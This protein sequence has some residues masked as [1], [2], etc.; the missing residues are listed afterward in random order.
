[1]DQ[2]LGS[3]ETNMINNDR[4]SSK[5]DEN[6]NRNHSQNLATNG[7]QNFLL[8]TTHPPI[9]PTANQPTLPNAPILPNP[10]I[11]DKSASTRTQ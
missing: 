7:N 10:K 3:Q 6:S 11:S 9:P 4:D 1:M 8:S 5:I 2:G